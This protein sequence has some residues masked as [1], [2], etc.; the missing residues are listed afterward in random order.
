MS[1]LSSSYGRSP[2]PGF[3]SSPRFGLTGSP[4][5]SKS[6]LEQRRR[7]RMIENQ[8]PERSSGLGS[9]SI[10][11]AVEPVQPAKSR[12]DLDRE[13]YVPLESKPEPVSADRGKEILE[14]YLWGQIGN[15][16]KFAVWW[17]AFSPLVLALFEGSP[18]GVGGA[19]TSFNMALFILSPLAGAVAERVSLRKLLNITTIFRGLIYAILLPLAWVMLQSGWV[20]AVKEYYTHIFYVVFLALVFFDGAMVAFSNVVDIDCGGTDILAKQHGAEVNDDTRNRFNSLHEV[21]FDLSMIVLSPLMALFAVLATNHLTHNTDVAGIMGMLAVVFF[22]AS[23]FSLYHYNRYIPS[24]RLHVEAN[25]ASSLGN[26]TCFDEFEEIARNIWLGMKMCWSHSAVRWR[27]IFLGLETSLEDAMISLIIAEFAVKGVHGNSSYAS[28]SLLANLI[29]ATGKIGAVIAAMLMHRYWKAPEDSADHNHPAFRRLFTWVFLGGLCTLLVPFAYHLRLQGYEFLSIFL[30][31]VSS[32]FFFLFSTAPKIGFGTLMQ[33]LAAEADAS[34][35]IFGF[36]A[37]FVTTTDSLVL[38]GLSSVFSFYSLQNALWV[39][40]GI[41][42]GHG[43][44]EYFFGPYLIL[45]P[46]KPD[47]PLLQA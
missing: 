44:L 21:W 43:F 20:I 36:V 42:A 41:I 1:Q 10:N 40:C 11:A 29:I 22:F 24:R 39:S 47:E 15:V 16:G 25:D 38:M 32:F 7:Q 13:G 2:K 46:K 35:R 45:S 31:F 28:G 6:E 23:I 33:S 19:R 26:R 18:Y 5:S 8:A 30:V 34:G 27:L 3:M 9:R 14:A 17:T 37:A 4:R 12:A